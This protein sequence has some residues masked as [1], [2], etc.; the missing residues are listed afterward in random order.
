[1]T[2]TFDE[3]TENP[4]GEALVEELRWIHGVIRSN[5]QTISL[6]VA[7]LNA[8]ASAEHT[9]AQINEL[10]STSAIWTLRVN[11]FHYCRL[12]HGHHHLEDIALF[13]YLRHFNP[14]LCPVIDRL[15][16]DHAIVSD[17]LDQVEAAAAA[18]LGADEAARS[19]LADALNGLAA[20]LL[21]HLDY[22]E[23]SIVSTLRRMDGLPIEHERNA[24]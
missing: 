9:R 23:T 8:G 15:E 3:S 6:V 22:E 2:K 11:C 21:T 12:A 5:L 18:R 19:I 13:P 17:Y 1:L 14:A 7:Q 16:A 20:Y 10:A 24:D 4:Q